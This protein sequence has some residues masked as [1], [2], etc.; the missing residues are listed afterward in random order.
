MLWETCMN[1]S[2]SICCFY[3]FLRG[4]Y[5]SVTVFS[6]LFLPPFWVVTLKIINNFLFSSL[7]TLPSE[8][9]YHSYFSFTLSSK[10]THVYATPCQV[11]KCPEFEKTARCLITQNRLKE[12]KALA[13][14]PQS[15]FTKKHI[16]SVCISAFS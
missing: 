3:F 8:S 16:V 11:M 15:T 7:V 4:N 9:L 14:W 2:N 10:I 12:S 6:S 5:H 1:E 13:I